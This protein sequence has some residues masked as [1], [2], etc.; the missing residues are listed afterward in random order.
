MV[1]WFRAGAIEKVRSVAHLVRNRSV[2]DVLEIGCGTGAVLERLHQQGIGR[3]YSGVD[4][5]P[6]AVAFTKQ[7]GLPY[8]R[9]EVGDGLEAAQLMDR[10]F[11]LVV[12][13]HILEHVPEPEAL[14]RSALRAGRA[15]FVE[16]PLESTV[17]LNLKW[18]VLEARGRDR[19]DNLAGHIHF[20]SKSTFLDL[21]NR[22]HARIIGTRQYVP[23]DDKLL[24]LNKTPFIKRKLMRLAYR[25]LGT[26]GYGRLWY[27]HFAVL[28][29]PVATT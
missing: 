1:Q 8:E 25:L 22:C 19:T 16:V 2:E 20:F 10:K 3:R 7:L 11:D 29:E 6:E 28:L 23:V 12:L 15:V 5:S 17:G 18:R 21:V 26:R 27:S 24:A 14:L 9:I 13:S 4:V